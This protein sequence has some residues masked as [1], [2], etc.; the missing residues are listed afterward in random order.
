[1]PS[2]EA[3]SVPVGVAFCAVFGPV[4]KSRFG[5]TVSADGDSPA[6][7]VRFT[8]TS[9]FDLGSASVEEIAERSSRISDKERGRA[10]IARL[11]DGE[12]KQSGSM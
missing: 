12:D 2:T 4:S 9:S 3:S 11:V 6:A 5:D 8:E 10:F 1:M 7:S